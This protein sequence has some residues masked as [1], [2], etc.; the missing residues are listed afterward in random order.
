VQVSGNILTVSAEHREDTK[1]HGY[2]YG[3]YQRSFTLPAGAEADKI[4]ARYH[5]GVLE[6]H[7]PKDKE[8][9]GR[10]I[11]VKSA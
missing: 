11:A 7:L 3:R 9:L 1:K 4:D 6:L 2:R 5:N 8:F 10:K